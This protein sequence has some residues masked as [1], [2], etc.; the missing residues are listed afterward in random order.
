MACN[1]CVDDLRQ[2]SELVAEFA[3]VVRRGAF[4]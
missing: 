2:T 3:N 1:E 4:G